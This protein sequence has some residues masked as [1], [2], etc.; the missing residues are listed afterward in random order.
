MSDV[1]TTAAAFS[2]RFAEYVDDAILDAEVSRMLNRYFDPSTV[3]KDFN[4]G[5]FG[6]I[7]STSIANAPDNQELPHL[8]ELSNLEFGNKLHTGATAIEHLKN[9]VS[10]HD[11]IEVQPPASQQPFAIQHSLVSG[12]VDPWLSQ[13]PSLLF[14]NPM[15]ITA[16]PMLGSLPDAVCLGSWNS[17]QYGPCN[18]WAITN[19]N[20]FNVIPGTV[21]VGWMDGRP[22]WANS[23]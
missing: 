17:D 12:S 1:H 19:I 10:S 7:I 5:A 9:L 4:F 2:S 8:T 23:N 13:P 21:I 11:E 18:V 22:V 6:N 20:S 16:D 15:E 3:R 14:S